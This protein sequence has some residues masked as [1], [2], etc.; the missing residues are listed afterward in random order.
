MDEIQRAQARHIADY[1]DGLLRDIIQTRRFDVE[2]AERQAQI[3]REN[4]ALVEA[5]AV[6][7]GLMEPRRIACSSCGGAGGHKPHPGAWYECQACEAEGTVQNPAFTVDL[8]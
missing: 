8:K 6:A 4:L 3:A 7:R 1:S 2:D 5:E